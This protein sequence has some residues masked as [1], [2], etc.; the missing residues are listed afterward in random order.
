[1]T[2]YSLSYHLKG[3][4]KKIWLSSFSLYSFSS[5]LI[6]LCEF[7]L[8]PRWILEKSLLLKLTENSRIIVTWVNQFFL[9][10]SSLSLTIPVFLALS[11]W[12]VFLDSYDC[13]GDQGKWYISIWQWFCERIFVTS[14]FCF[15]MSSVVSSEVW[16]QCL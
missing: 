11:L 3:K 6:L 10:S 7:I 16:N 5:L 12:R 2:W 9:V 1:M 15:W 4:K 13:Q 14:L 8:N